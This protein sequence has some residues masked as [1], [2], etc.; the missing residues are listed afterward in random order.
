MSDSERSTDDRATARSKW[1]YVWPVLEHGHYQDTLV[2]TD[3]RWLFA[4]RREVTRDIGY[5]PYKH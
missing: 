3:G 2:R 1:A 4:R 5:A